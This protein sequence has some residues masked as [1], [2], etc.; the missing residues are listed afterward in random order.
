[1]ADWRRLAGPLAA[2]VTGTGPRIVFVHGFTQT[3]QSMVDIA[4]RVVRLGFQAAVVDLPGH[5]ESSGVRADLRRTADLLAATTGPAIYVGYSLGGRVCLHLALM[6]PH[7]VHRLALIGATPGII[8]DDERAMRRS[9]DEALARHIVEVGVPQFIDEWTA[10]PLFAGLTLS[11]AE[12]DDRLRNTATGLAESLRLSGTGTQLPLWDR[13]VELNMPVLAMAGE[14]D[15]KFVPVAER[16]AAS[17]PHGT[18]GQ[19]HDAGHSAHLQ[20]PMQVVTR[21]EVW[22][23]G[24]KLALAT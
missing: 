7:V 21:L 4:Q 13:L 19:I 20:Q 14:L 22:L 1:M 8:D 3:G 12:R 15:T 17:A 23:R 16:I 9:A 6:Y 24:S 18:F 2:R 5:G 10:Q 11:Q